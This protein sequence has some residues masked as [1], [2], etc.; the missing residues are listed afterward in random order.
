MKAS[1]PQAKETFMRAHT[2]CNQVAEKSVKK[3]LNMARKKTLIEKKR[4]T[5]KFSENIK[6]RKQ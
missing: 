2:H 5:V 4:R 1:K 6:G 3:N